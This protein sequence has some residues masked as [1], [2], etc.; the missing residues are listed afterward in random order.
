VEDGVGELEVQMGLSV[1]SGNWVIE[2]MKLLQSALEC[3]GG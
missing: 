2:L 3:S 1:R